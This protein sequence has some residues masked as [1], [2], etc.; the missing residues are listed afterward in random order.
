MKKIMFLACLF[1]VILTSCENKERLNEIKASLKNEKT[2][3]A[4][5]SNQKVSF[6]SPEQNFKEKEE[7]EEDYGDE[8]SDYESDYSG[9]YDG[10]Y[11][12]SEE[13]YEPEYESEYEDY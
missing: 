12:E 4:S 5:D 6:S 3:A 10:G 8:T 13:E 11:S 2:N 9:E 7:S 1:L